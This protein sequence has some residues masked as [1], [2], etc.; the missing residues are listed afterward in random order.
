[1][2]QYSTPR[3]HALRYSLQPPAMSLD[4]RLGTVHWYSTVQY[5]EVQWSAVQFA[6]LPS[7]TQFNQWSASESR[8]ECDCQGV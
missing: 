7:A 3:H 5:T 8:C 2:A 1:M 6:T 4:C